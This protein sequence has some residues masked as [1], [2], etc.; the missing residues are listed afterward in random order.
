M[1][2]RKVQ[3]KKL[4]TEDYR[5]FTRSLADKYPN[6]DDIE[7]SYMK[8]R[9]QQLAEEAHPSSADPNAG[10]IEDAFPYNKIEMH[11]KLDKIQN[12]PS[13]FQY[14]HQQA[15]GVSKLPASASKHT[16][17]IALSKPWTGVETH[18]DASL[19]M[20]NDSI[21]P[22]KVKK[23]SN[24]IITPP[25]P[26]RERIHDAREGALD[27]RLA[28]ISNG[29]GKGKAAK[30]RGE[31]DDE[32][33]EMYRERLLGPSM[34]LNDSFASV[35]NSIKS[36]ADQR[37]MDAQRR[38]EFKNI[39][40]GKPLE[41]GYGSTENMFVDRTEYHLNQILKRQ[42]AL[43]PWIEKQGGCDLRILR[44]REE[45]DKEW[46]QW[47]LNRV[48]GKFPGASEEE[49]V[50]RMATYAKNE[51]ED[52]PGGERLRGDA[53]VQTRRRHLDSKLRD[54]NDTI[55][56]YNLQAPLASQKL[57]LL[58]DKELA[59][60]Y[61]RV[62]P[63]LVEAF[64]KHLRGDDGGATADADAATAATHSYSGLPQRE[65]V[66]QHETESL[67]SMFKK[68]FW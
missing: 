41:K 42:D 17:D 67:G 12:D 1:F 63:L 57:Y 44:F 39:R 64:K 55:R 16:R 5:F 46:L 13:N 10:K 60:C 28:K 52:T 2:L 4:V 66:Y 24:T 29:G 56:G 19:R 30:Q 26:I 20:L 9:L 36:L 61:K 68:M 53:W 40:R 25:Q 47:V 3:A 21:K 11:A 37:I 8:R 51:L 31:D 34:L 65:N 49:L 7:G 45:L 58:L 48:K 59:G 38:G 18:Y 33:A 35:D 14:Q 23:S 6:D 43:P 62:A 15:I 54:L 27:Y 22:M 32:W 50:A